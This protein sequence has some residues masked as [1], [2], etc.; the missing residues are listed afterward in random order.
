MDYVGGGQLFDYIM[1]MNKNKMKIEGK[2]ARFYAAQITLVFDYMHN[3][4]FIYRDLKPEHVL[5][6]NDGYLKL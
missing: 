1:K 2:I 3:K 5:I 6:H 4:Q